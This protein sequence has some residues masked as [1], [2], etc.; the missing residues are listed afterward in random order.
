M[1]KSLWARRY[2]KVEKKIECGVL[3]DLCP[4]FAHKSMAIWTAVGD[5]LEKDDLDWYLCNH[6]FEYKI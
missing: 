4:V 2:I 6:F 1:E 5:I 3:V